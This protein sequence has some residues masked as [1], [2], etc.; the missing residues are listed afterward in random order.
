MSNHS[1]SYMLN[2][3]LRL[4]SEKEVFQQIGLDKSQD[5]VKEILDIAARYD[6]NTGEILEDIGRELK[7]CIYCWEKSTKINYSGY[8]LNCDDDDEDD[9]ELE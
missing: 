7:I 2:R 4:L 9:D 3:V 8:C 1:G 6:C 5:I